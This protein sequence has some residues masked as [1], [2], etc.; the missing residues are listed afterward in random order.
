ME[1]RLVIILLCPVHFVLEPNIKD[2]KL[3]GYTF[4]EAEMVMV[5]G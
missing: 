1:I 3:I 4:L 5:Q 2:G